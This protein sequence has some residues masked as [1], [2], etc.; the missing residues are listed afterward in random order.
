MNHESA[1]INQVHLCTRRLLVSFIIR[2]V[3][4][5]RHTFALKQPACSEQK[6]IQDEITEMHIDAC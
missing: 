2:I 5:N 6:Q 3:S 1:Y 4:Y